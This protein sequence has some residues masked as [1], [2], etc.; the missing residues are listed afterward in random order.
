MI[1]KIIHYVWISETGDVPQIVKRC[2]SSWKKHCPDYEIKLW[3]KSN[4]PDVP[5]VRSCIARGG[6]ALGF[7]VD[8][9]K[10]WCLH[11]YGGVWCDA[12]TE[13]A[14]PIDVLMNSRGFVFAHT[15][16]EKMCTAFM[17]AEKG[18]PYFR[19]IMKYYE[20]KEIWEDNAPRVSQNSIYKY[21]E[22]LREQGV[23]GLYAG[24]EQPIKRHAENTSVNTD[25]FMVY[26]CNNI[27]D[28]MGYAYHH[29]MGS[30]LIKVPK[31]M[32][33]SVLISF[34]NEGEEVLRTVQSIRAGDKDIPIIVLD[35][36]SNDGYDYRG[37]LEPYGVKLVRN[38]ASV[39][40]GAGKEQVVQMCETKWFLLLDAHCRM[41]T[42]RW[43]ELLERH[44]LDERGVYCMQMRSFRDSDNILSNPARVYGAKIKEKGWPLNFEWNYNISP[45]PTQEGDKV[46][47]WD[48][49]GESTNKRVPDIW[50]IL[51]AN[52]VSTVEWWNRIHGHRGLTGYGWEEPFVSWKTR[53][54]GGKVQCVTDIVT[55]HKYRPAPYKKSWAEYVYNGLFII[56][57][58]FPEAF[59]V[60]MEGFRKKYGDKAVQEAIQL[61]ELKKDTCMEEMAYFRGLI[62]NKSKI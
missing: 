52:Y 18:S 17:G 35:D 59:V 19:H 3:D 29:N 12:D 7:L 16:G 9:V 28:N 60:N 23:G 62:E 14:A 31:A 20:D 32:D 24:S 26:Y 38:E 27:D 6:W 25:G 34:K 47:A 4:L 1:P 10:A 45:V 49:K 33:I 8:Y 54:L 39:G 15:T 48:F 2:I 42:P 41:L 51:G 40:S 5:W 53:L 44:N 37:K 57:V 36:G 58:C 56:A 50:C 21:T 46:T 11:T 43:R 55:A 13:I 30:W 22:L 61:F